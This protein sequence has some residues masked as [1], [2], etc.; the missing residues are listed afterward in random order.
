[1]VWMRRLQLAL[2]G[3]RYRLAGSL[4][5]LVVAVIAVSAAT[6]GPM[7]SGT[8][9]DSLVRHR[10]ATTPVFGT[11]LVA[12]STL[13]DPTVSPARVV[14]ET[15]AAV[16]DARY[17]RLW[18][19]SSVTVQTGKDMVT[20]P[21]HPSTRY[22]AV[23]SWRQGMCTSVRV[24][25]GRC[26]ADA[27]AGGGSEAMVSVRTASDQRVAVGERLT[28][29]LQA[30]RLSGNTPVVV[31][32]YDQT[33]GTAPGWV[34]DSPV[35]AAAAGPNDPTESIDEVLVDRATVIAARVD[36]R[37]TAFRPLRTASVHARD[38]TELAALSAPATISGISVT[39]SAAELVA[40]IGS[41]R[42]LVRS[43]STAV[44]VQLALL[45]LFV[46][47][48]VLAAAA[49]ERGPEV[50][51]AK[52]RG[53]RPARTAV[54]TL[55]EPVV[56][57]VVA[58]PFGV[59]VALFGDRVL[60]RGLSDGSEIS[61]GGAAAAAA[62]MALA[63]GV[64]A[65]A[66]AARRLLATP[67]LGQLR[68]T[69][70]RRAGLARSVA[71]DSAA[72]AVAAA[73]VYEL[74]NGS[75][76]LVGL[77]APGLVAL[78]AGLLVVRL[79]P[80]AARIAVRRT[81]HS[82]GVVGFLAARNTARR[83]AGS[84]LVV[85]LAVA[86]ALTVFGVNGDVVARGV[87]SQ[88]A[89]AQI[90]AATVVHVTSDGPGVLL[91]AVRA[92]DPTGRS[93]MAA[94]QSGPGVIPSVVALDAARL[95]AVSRWDP[96]WAGTSPGALVT[97]LV[98][99]AGAPVTA[100][101]TLTGTWSNSADGPAGDLHAT[102]DLLTGTG[103]RVTADAGRIAPGSRGALR[104]ELPAGCVSAPCRLVGWDFT[105]AGSAPT[106]APPPAD[107]SGIAAQ[108]PDPGT[109]GVVT[110]TG[111]AD[112]RGSLSVPADPTR[113]RWRYGLS[114]A[115][116]IDSGHVPDVEVSDDGTAG[117]TVTLQ[118]KSDAPFTI[119]P[120]DL[121]STPAA[122][123]GRNAPAQPFDTF[124]T[125]VSAQDL[126]GSPTLFTPVPGRGVLP[127]IGTDGVLV[128]LGSLTLGHPLSTPTVD[129]QVWFAGDADVTGI[130]AR[131]ATAGV[132]PVT[133]DPLRPVT[134]E[135]IAGQERELAAN[136][137]AVGLRLYVLAAVASVL[138]ALGALLTAAF[139]AARRRSYEVAAV[140]ALGGR[141]G[142]LTLAGVLEQLVVV[143]TG[144]GVGV[145]VGVVVARLALPVLGSITAG[146]PTTPAL[147][148][149]VPVAGVGVAV[150]VL[151]AVVA[152]LASRRVVHLAGPDRLREVQ[153]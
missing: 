27:P 117:F 116:L 48:L 97:G 73:G 36:V 64:A 84:R 78:A 106:G 8:A 130:L 108:P 54:F 38:M 120:T 49:E 47:Y 55:A 32:V 81:R 143:V 140:L 58:L 18:G 109:F 21:G 92:A 142:V 146:G 46:L 89:R 152:V 148:A 87:R 115:D 94:A 56:L 35:Q 71:L 63:G 57:L 53:M 9:Q 30:P 79:V 29:D 26:P 66:L 126:T 86:V 80:V 12:T 101:G 132:R 118:P 102:V 31:G 7:Y 134:T 104:A 50:A 51:L 147:I 83:P 100:Q 20:F 135:T 42:Q 111:L 149:W 34:F 131:L 59:A 141:P 65:A 95:G 44:T 68:R 5:A 23:V 13:A 88:T 138:L 124:A 76:D 129:D 61:F 96:A 150:I 122:L 127:R 128:D 67:V 37:V 14:D 121:P 33:S 52:L 72:V 113:K 69:G 145:A 60:A 136:G 75:S 77:A 153:A 82:P 62:L 137:P 41:D 22:S 110:V 17:D 3:T 74:V 125:T 91:A 40:A 119:A 25:R 4:M 107:N 28:A 19:A 10:L 99:S 43:A 114:R 151:A 90:G 39:S 6:L 112:A 70:G 24:V 16:G 139:V 2:L 11:G 1:V 98:P 45:A 85:L 15:A 105:R 123:V 133:G 93:A 144:T 103:R